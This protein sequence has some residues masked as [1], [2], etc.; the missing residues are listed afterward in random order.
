MSTGGTL[1]WTGLAL[2]GASRVGHIDDAIAALEN[3]RFSEEELGR[4]DGIVG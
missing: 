1:F 2:I 3:R 4:I